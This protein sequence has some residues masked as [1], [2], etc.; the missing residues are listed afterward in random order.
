MTL[1]NKLGI[2]DAVELAREEER[3]SK[4]RAIE[5][6]EDKL[7]DFQQ[8]F[9][10]NCRQ[11]RRVD[12]R[13]LFGGQAFLPAVVGGADFL[14]F[15]GRIKFQAEHF[16]DISFSQVL[17]SQKIVCADIIRKSS[18]KQDL[19]RAGIKKIPRCV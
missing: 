10:A 12:G 3:L 2:A 9:G 11:P 19:R 6:F 5:L 17:P 7:L 18:L 8:K 14:L 13:I 16:K 15:V 1:E 4:K